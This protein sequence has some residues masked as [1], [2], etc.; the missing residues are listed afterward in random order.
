MYDGVFQVLQN[1]SSLELA[2]ASFHLL[3]DLGKQYPR[4]YL[5]DSD[6]HQSLVVVKES[7]LPL[8]IGNGSHSSEIRGNARISD[9]LFDPSRFSLLIEAMVEPA[10]PTDDNNGIKAIENMMLFQYLVNTLEADFVPRHIAYKKSLDWVFFR[11]SLLNMLLGSR[12][13]VFKSLVKNC[14]YLLLNQ[15]HPEVEDGVEGSIPSEGEAKSASDMDSSLNYLLLESERTLVSLRKL[16]V[17]VMELDLIRKEADTLGLTSR[18]D[19]FRNPIMEVILDELIYNISYLSPFL[20]A[21][22]EWKWKLEIIL[23]YFSKYCGKGA[24]RTRRSDSSQQDLKLGSVLSFF[25]TTT[26]A[27]AIVKKMGTEVAQL[28]LAHAYQVCLY[29]QSDSSDSTATTEKIGASLQEI[30]CDFISAFQNLRKV[31]LNIQI[32]PF[33][34]EALFTAATLSRKLKNEER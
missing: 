1:S 28:L 20:L 30:S 21:F 10:N 29:V 12:K 11:E 5:T 19:G 31:G 25:L 26:S 18:A 33:E 27:K 34:K 8:L 2:V 16:F 32:S 17:M 4:T 22:M 6:G 24:V 15:F 13:L 3:M 7:W 14:M 9:H 23:Q